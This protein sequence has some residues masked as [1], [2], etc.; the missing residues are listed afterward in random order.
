MTLPIARDLMKVGVRVCTVAPGLFN[1]PLLQSLPEEVQTK[2]GATIPFPSRL[3]LPDEY[4][5]LV[6]AIIENPVLN[7]EVIRLDGALRMQP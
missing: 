4:A 5:H 1:T 2:L 6:Q 3:G 7:G